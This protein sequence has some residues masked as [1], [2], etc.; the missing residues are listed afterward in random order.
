MNIPC[1]QIRAPLK[2]LRRNFGTFAVYVFLVVTTFIQLHLFVFPYAPFRE[3]TLQLNIQF[4]VANVF[5]LLAAFKEPGYVKSNP[6]VK[7]EKLV[8]KFDANSLCPACETIY[9]SDS[10]H[11]YICNRCIHKFDHHCQWINNCVGRNNHTVFYAYIVSLLGY[12]FSLF[13]MCFL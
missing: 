5:F 13:V 11:C 4:V 10:R 7:F 12:F 3:W 8:E 2:E 1:S 9:S 6:L